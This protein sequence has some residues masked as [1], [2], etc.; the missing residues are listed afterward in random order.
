M[1]FAK[2]PVVAHRGAFKM[3]QLPQNSIAS[4]QE[5]IRLGCSGTEFDIHRT[6]DDSLLI[7][8]DADYA[9]LPIEKT[10]YASL[11][12]AALTRQEKLPTLREYLLAGSTNN[13]STALILEIKPSAIHKENGLKTAQM[14]W[15]LVQE[16]A[17]QDYCSYISFDEDILKKIRSLDARAG[18]QYLKGDKSPA[19]LYQAGINGLDYPIS[20]FKKKPE[21]ITEAKKLGL[22]LN[23]WTVNEAEDLNWCLEQKFDFITTNEPE[24]LLRLW[25]EKSGE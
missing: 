5:A 2:N 10:N 12:A 22:I 21:W 14:V 13:N 9:G 18:L 17:L 16:L 15:S 4:L 8:H 7:N 24:L 11:M 1:S 23:V 20:V 19:E 6:A 25:K 3:K